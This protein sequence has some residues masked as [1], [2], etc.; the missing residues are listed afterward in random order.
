MFLWVL[1][2]CEEKEERVL[3]K[4]MIREIKIDVGGSNSR[5]ARQGNAPNP[6]AK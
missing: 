4:M 6:G 2:G 1:I 5:H 3:D